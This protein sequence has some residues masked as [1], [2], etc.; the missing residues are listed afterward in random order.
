MGS[1]I[2]PPVS[3]SFKSLDRNSSGFSLLELLVVLVIMGIMLGAVSLNAVQSVRQRLQTDAQRISLLMQLAR[4]E[5][6]VRNRQTAFEVF[7]Q[8]Y[9]FLVLNDNK[10][11]KIEDLDTLRGRQFTFPETK[12]SI[13]SNDTNASER[14]RIVF[15][16][17]PVSRPFTMILR[18]GNDQVSINADGVGHFVV[19]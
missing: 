15:G 19:E 12:L 6:I 1:V 11:E 8:G 10:W 18:V 5:A 16:R 9:Q 2:R 17:E 3:A 14:L 4:E 13:I 7:E